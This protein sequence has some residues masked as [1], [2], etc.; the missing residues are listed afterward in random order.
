[1]PNKERKVDMLL[2]ILTE[3]EKV[4]KCLHSEDTIIQSARV[5]LESVLE[6][7]TEL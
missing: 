1:M 5:Y 4:K 3:L 6:S 7:Y 2:A